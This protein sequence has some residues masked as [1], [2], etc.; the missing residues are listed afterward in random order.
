MASRVGGTRTSRGFLRID[1]RLDRLMQRHELLRL[2]PDGSISLA[3]EDGVLL[4]RT[5]YLRH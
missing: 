2:Q 3:R 1:L 5:P 4:T